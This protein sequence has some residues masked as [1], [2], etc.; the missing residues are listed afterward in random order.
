MT[1]IP[2]LAPAMDRLSE[3]L[4]ALTTSHANN[5]TS[6]DSLAKDREDVGEKEGEMRAMIEKAEEKR[7]WFSGFRDWIEGMAN[8]LDEKVLCVAVSRRPR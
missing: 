8:F 3:R 1:P 2:S 7:A 6:L 4:A 5:M